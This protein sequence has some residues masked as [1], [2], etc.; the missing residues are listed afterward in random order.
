[1]L[2]TVHLAIVFYCLSVLLTAAEVD[3]PTTV[4]LL[5]KLSPFTRFRAIWRFVEDGLEPIRGKTLFPTA[6]PEYVLYI[7]SRLIS[8]KSVLDTNKRRMK[9]V[10]VKLQRRRLKEDSVPSVF[11]MPQNIAPFLLYCY[12]LVRYCVIWTLVL[13]LL[14]FLEIV[15]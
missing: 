12:P 9:T 1:M 5:T 4:K 11:L 8:R 15:C 14:L 7:F 2:T 10:S 3:R 6:Y 13:F